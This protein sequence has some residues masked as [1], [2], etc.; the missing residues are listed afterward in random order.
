MAGLYIHVPFCAKRCI[1][2]DFY[3]QTDMHL[4]DEYVKVLVRELELRA[5]YLEGEPV[6]TIY[7]GGGTPSQLQA[8]DFELLFNAISKYYDL[9]ACEEVTLE[10][11]PDDITN[12]YLS[13]LLRFPFNRIS[14]GVQSF[15]D[16]EL[17]FLNRR[18]NREQAIAA[19]HRCR[20]AGFSNLSIDLMYG[21]PQQTPA[22]WETNLTEALR[23]D[24]PHISA[25]HLSYEE[26][27][28]IFRQVET[29]QI[30]PVEEETSIQLFHTLTDT[31]TDAGYLH[32]EISNF[33]KPGQFA[34]HNTSYWKDRKYLGIGPA[35]HSYNHHSR[36][37]NIASL[38][39]Y[40]EKVMNENSFFEKELLNPTTRY[41]DYILTH[42]RTMWGI[43]TDELAEKFGQSGY[44]YFMKQA[45]PYFATKLLKNNRGVI[46]L[47]TQGIF[48]SDSIFR[49]LIK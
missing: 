28:P 47:A 2:C 11:N 18:H 49:D 13:E 17:Q 23:L 22:I 37:W 10:A 44:D 39:E 32:Y 20:E 7:F 25:Y 4:K 9:S 43:R 36:Q 41:N 35:A 21:L 12:Q 26:G 29:G 38:R 19:V 24:V 33:C 46:T 27:T 6:N 45:T 15:N 30:Y 42:L 5:D 8:A 31:L 34:Q 48:V 40:I 16:R 3:S 14:L 1:Y